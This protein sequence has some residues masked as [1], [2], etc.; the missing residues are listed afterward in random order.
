MFPV[1]KDLKG[2]FGLTDIEKQ[3]CKSPQCITVKSRLNFKLEATSHKPCDSTKARSLDRVLSGILVFTNIDDVKQRGYHIGT[4]KWD[5]SA[6]QLTG[7]LSGVTNAGTHREPYIK[8]DEKC[9]APGHMEG[10]LD[11]V[12]VGGEHK[13]CRLL[14]AYMIDFGRFEKPG[15]NPGAKGTLEG[16]LICACAG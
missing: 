11:A 1:S 16:V 10:R 13:G 9:Y 8:C 12:V 5:T 7:R 4:F 14:A 6:S 15:D 2:G 3:E